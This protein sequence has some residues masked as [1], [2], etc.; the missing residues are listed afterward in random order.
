MS[1]WLLFEVVVLQGWDDRH[2]GLGHILT[3][4]VEDIFSLPTTATS[5]N[6]FRPA[7]LVQHK[8]SI[9]DKENQYFMEKIGMTKENK[10]ITFPHS[11]KNLYFAKF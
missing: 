7:T 2:A 1:T 4:G 10:K 3:T 11:W 6:Y 9:N 8:I 5:H